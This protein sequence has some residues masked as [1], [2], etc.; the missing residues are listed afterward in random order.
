MS[1]S[2]FCGSKATKYNRTKKIFGQCKCKY[3]KNC[4]K[5]VECSPLYPLHYLD[6]R[7]RHYFVKYLWYTHLVLWM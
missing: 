7:F 4:Y 5:E 3:E 2:L 1:Q 6:V